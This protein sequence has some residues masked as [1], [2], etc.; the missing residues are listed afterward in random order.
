[1][2]DHEIDAGGMSTDELDSEVRSLVSRSELE[3]AMLRL[4]LRNVSAELDRSQ[5]R[6]NWERVFRRS[7]GFSFEVVAQTRQMSELLEVR[8]AAPPADVG[9]GFLEFL[10]RQQFDDQNERAET[11]ALAAEV[12][13]E[14]RELVLSQEAD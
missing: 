8:F 11:A 2:L 12:M 4:V 14:A 10:G 7:G 1:M 9:R 6:A 5:A 3:G 13:A